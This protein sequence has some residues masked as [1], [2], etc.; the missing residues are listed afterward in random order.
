MAAGSSDAAP[1][2]GAVGGVRSP[3]SGTLQL[4]VSASDTGAG[5]AYAEAS[6]DGAPP[7]RVRLGHGACPEDPVAGTEPPP[8]ADCP[9]SVSGVL[10]ALDT[11]A[12]ADGERL[13]RV[14]VAD[15]AG[16]TATLV[17]RAIA[18]RNAPRA[19]GTVASVTVGI[20]SGGGGSKGGEAGG[21]AGPSGD[22]GHAQALRRKGSC[23]A[24]RLKMRL[25]R[26]PLWRTR[27]R[28]VPV[29]RYGRRYPFKGR[30]TCLNPSGRRVAAPKGTRV[31]VYYRVWRR[32][33]KRP[34]GPVRKLR[35]VTLR[36]RKH[37]RLRTKLGFRS[38]R[39]LIFRYRSP[40]GRPAK[41]KLRLAV[42]PRSRRAP[43]GPR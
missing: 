19:G 32:S 42:P 41:A 9:E 25:A 36:V 43:W 10:L 13:L 21:G 5:L 31:G 16:N 26:R 37:G 34:W 6:L 28:H 29:L 11:N 3:A 8:G 40:G 4:R 30:L 17:N 24:P 1:P 2:E 15:G 22:R 38:G 35:R 14:W 7:V 33:F 12:V 20:G 27:P 39:T 23:R 18:V